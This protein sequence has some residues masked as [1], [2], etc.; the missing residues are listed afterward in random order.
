MHAISSV[1]GWFRAA[2][3]RSKQLRSAP[4][5]VFHA[6]IDHDWRIERVHRMVLPSGAV[7]WGLGSMGRK[8]AHVAVWR[9]RDG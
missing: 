8:R 9:V 7:M 4:L 6:V 3:S 1:F 5:L 2:T